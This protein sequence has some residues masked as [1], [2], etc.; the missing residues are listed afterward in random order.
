[1]PTKFIDAIINLLKSI[2]RTFS[3]NPRALVSK[4]DISVYERMFASAVFETAFSDVYRMPTFKMREQ[5]WDECIDKQVGSSMKM[6]YVEFGVHKGDSIRCFAEKNVNPESAFIGLDSFEGLPEDWGA[7]P[8]GSFD[9]RGKIPDSNDSRVSFIKG[10]FQDTWSALYSQLQTKTLD[11]LVVHYD[12]DLYSSTL[13]A[14]SQIDSL[15]KSYIAI[16]DEFPGHEARALYNYCQAYNASVSFIAVT[17]SDRSAPQATQ[18]MC[19]ITP[20]LA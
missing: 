1:M 16:F 18:V 14:L 11:S 4:V 10:W 17:V 5:L 13:F 15:K 12:A 9:T 20:H 19:R 3:L 7:M 6:T 2:S 8:K